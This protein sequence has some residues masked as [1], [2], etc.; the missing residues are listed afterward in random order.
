MDVMRLHKIASFSIALALVTAVAAGLTVLNSHSYSGGSPLWAMISRF[1][2]VLVFGAF[3]LTVARASHLKGSLWVTAEEWPMTIRDFVNFGVLPGAV[4][5]IIN[6]FF[7]FS[8]R[9][10][11]SV[12]PRVR[13]IQ[14]YYD[15][16]L[17]SLDSGMAEEIIY[18]L[19]IFS[20]FIFTFRHLQTRQPEAMALVLSSLLFAM[21]HSFS[22]FSAAFFGGMLLGVIYLKSGIEGAIAAH[23]IANFVF[24]SAAYLR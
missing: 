19:F 9:Y 15:S 20:C 22:A 10:S 11:P 8:Y 16:F 7:F 3:G 21:V 6:F 5:G 23:F 12:S 17:L 14:S 2:V 13:D 4:L 1:V 24:F 18:R